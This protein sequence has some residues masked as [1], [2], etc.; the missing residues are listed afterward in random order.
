MKPSLCTAIILGACLT[1]C[2][3]GEVDDG[4]FVVTGWCGDEYFS[5]SVVNGTIIARQEDEIVTQMTTNGDGEFEAELMAGTYVVSCSKVHRGDCTALGS[6]TVDIGSGE[7]N[8][9]SIFHDSSHC[10]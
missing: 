5:S 9:V 1:A 8:H 7:E 6:E 3:S 4:P 2:S 10:Y